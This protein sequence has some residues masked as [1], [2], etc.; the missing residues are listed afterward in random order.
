[1]QRRDFL[2]AT[3]AATLAGAARAAPDAGSAQTKSPGLVQL[4]S[5]CIEI[6]EECLAHCYQQ[7]AAGDTSLAGCAKSVTMMLS[8][9]R[10]LVTA[11]A[12]SAPRLKEIARVCGQVCRDCEAS[13]K[14]HAGH[15]DICRRCMEACRACA[16]ACEKTA[17]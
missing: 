14:P 6:G 17:A 16:A 9:C 11:A 7:L 10:A 4:A 2:I 13:C 15:H 3:G 5:D 1:M 8:M 12:Q